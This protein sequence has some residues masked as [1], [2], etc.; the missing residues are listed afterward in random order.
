MAKRTPKTPFP[1]VSNFNERKFQPFIRVIGQSTLLWNDLHEWLGSL[2]AIAMGG[3]V[4]NVHFVNRH[5]MGTP[6]RRPRGTPVSDV[7][8]W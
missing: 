4:V 2:Y 8:W 1:W 3:G 5:W 6:D 7:F